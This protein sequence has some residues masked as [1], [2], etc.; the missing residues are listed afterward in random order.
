VC[1][2]RAMQ[3]VHIAPIL[4]DRLLESFMGTADWM[5]NKEN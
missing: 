4:L 3:D 1:M 2:G 5:R